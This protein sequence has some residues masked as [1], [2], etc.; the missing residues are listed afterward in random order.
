MQ[1]PTRRVRGPPPTFED[2]VGASAHA[3]HLAKAHWVHLTCT[4]SLVDS[5][6]VY[7][8]YTPGPPLSDFI[9]YF[10]LLS[11]APPHSRE[12]VLPSG[13]IELVVNLRDDEFQIFHPKTPDRGT[14][15]S[16][17]IVSGTYGGCF[18]IDTAQHASIMG[19]HFKPGG[20]FPFLG[21]PIRDFTDQHVDLEVLWGRSARRLRERVCRATTPAERFGLIE[22]ALTAHVCRPLEHHNAVATAPRSSS[23]TPASLSA[24]SRGSSA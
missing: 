24:K 3:H 4:R 20:A 18:V 1:T 17:A 15:Y 11:D 22:K 12:R 10:W 2:R 13:T 14:R 23:K 8:S 21:P 19:V 7:R 16:G 9:D 5:A 6:M